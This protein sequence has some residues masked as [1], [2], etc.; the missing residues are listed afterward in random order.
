MLIQVSEWCLTISKGCDVKLF[1]ATFMLKVYYNASYVCYYY[2]SLVWSL[3]N[4]YNPYHGDAYINLFI[5]KK[6]PYLLICWWLWYKRHHVPCIYTLLWKLTFFLGYMFS[7]FCIYLTYVQS[8]SM[9]QLIMYLA[10]PFD[11]IFYQLWDM[12]IF[13]S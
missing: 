13:L 7:F 2:F 1:Q 10:V 3:T 9:I 11:F 6:I 8:T 5:S 12:S 4:L